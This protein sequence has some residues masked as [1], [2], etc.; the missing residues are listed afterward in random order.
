ML[1]HVCQNWSQILQRLFWPNRIVRYHIARNKRQWISSNEKMSLFHLGEIFGCGVAG[2][3]DDMSKKHSNMYKIWFL[4][5]K[6]VE[7]KKIYFLEEWLLFQNCSKIKHCKVLE[8]DSDKSIT[9][10]D[11]KND[12]LAVGTKEGSVDI[13]QSD[14]HTFSC[15]SVI[16]THSKAVLK[17]VL[18]DSMMVS[19]SQDCSLTVVKFL[20]SGSLLVSHVLQVSR[21]II[22]SDILN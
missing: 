11:Y 22:Q 13:Y 20:D 3:N 4:H 19:C 1:G 5:S 10:S 15:I 16:N 14:T 12:I 17:I 7:D 2:G 8:L 9:C 21:N 6:S 18:S